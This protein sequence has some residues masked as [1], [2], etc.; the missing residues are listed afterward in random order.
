MEFEKSAARM[1]EIADIM[2]NGEVTLEESIRLF[3]ESVKIAKECVD[4][5]SR[6]KGK[7]TVLKKESDQIFEQPFE[8]REE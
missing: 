5:L 1:K 4:I 2:E 8:E 3:D 6:T 7:I